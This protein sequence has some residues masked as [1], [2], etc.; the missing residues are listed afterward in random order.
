MTEKTTKAKSAAKAP[1]ADE[2]TLT[3]RITDGAREF[4]KRS[5]SSAK[6]RT[7][8]AFNSSKQYNA[9]L[10]N[11]LVRAARGYVNILGNFAEA[12]YVNVNRG[13]EAAEKLAD[14]KSL[15]EAME[16]QST[17]VREQST[18]SM[19]NARSAMEYMRDVVTEGGETLRDNATKMWK[20][21]KAA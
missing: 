7:D 10:E 15:S 5:T 6:E 19:N 3:D 18:C 4:V 16:I 13:I 17:Y 14:A 21:D 11:L 8:S 2:N 9:D 12:A 20:S 1:V